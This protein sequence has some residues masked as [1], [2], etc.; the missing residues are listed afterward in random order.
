MSIAPSHTLSNAFEVSVECVID[1]VWAL[2]PPATTGYP[3]F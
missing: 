3:M 2:P 1:F